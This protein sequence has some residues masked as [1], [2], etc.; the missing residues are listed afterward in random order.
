MG[1]GLTQTEV[2]TRLGISRAACSK[3]ETSPKIRAP[4]RRRIAL[5]LRISAE[6]LV[7]A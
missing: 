1:C 5:A 4:R 3:L 6:Q 7:Q 2:A